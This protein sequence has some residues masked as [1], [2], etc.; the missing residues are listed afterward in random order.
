MDNPIIIQQ[1][2]QDSA[3]PAATSSPNGEII[4]K[5]E[6]KPES[7][8]QTPFNPP[9][10]SP[11]NR[12]L[13]V[14]DKP[15]RPLNLWS[16]I[17]NCIFI[18]DLSKLPLPVNFCEP[19]SILQRLTE[20]YEYAELFDKA[21]LCED[22]SEQL[23]YI[24]AFLVSCYSTSGRTQKPFNSL[25]GET[26]ECD[27]TDDLGW[28][29]ISEK[30]SH[31]PPMAA[32]YCEG[33]GW[34]CWREFTVKSKFKAGY[35][36]IIPFGFTY[37]EFPGSGNKYSWQRN[38]VTVVHNIIFGKLWND[39]HGMLEITGK[40]GAAGYTSQLTYSPYYAQ[41]SNEIKG[42]VRDP[43]KKAR[44]VLRGSWETKVEYAVV[45]STGSSPDDYKT[46]DYRTIWT[47]RMPPPDSPKYYNFT[48][49]ACQLNEPEDGVAPTDSRLR[50]DQRLMET[51]Q[52][53][54][55]NAE[56]LKLE[57]KQRAFL[58]EREKNKLGPP[59]PIWFRKQ[60]AEDSDNVVHVFGGEYWDCKAK[61]D[62]S[63]CPAIFDDA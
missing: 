36:E 57:A 33:R 9:I 7:L 48:V 19:L 51:T 28:R 37:L 62:W 42:V 13:R 44:W 32:Q 47:R 23:A 41:D 46:D 38:I 22:T 35:I 34:R 16:I 39:H 2:G 61:Q 49:L 53:D 18:D 40:A 11:I 20:D 27:R 15:N 10:R 50:P 8:N 63:R 60:K 24:T 1:H 3:G 21:A 45:I 59:A 14:P 26:F 52:W 54:E 43:E 56:K 31:H 17:K 58:L 6:S 4:N 12:R 30:V 5:Q 55:S 29:C 25:L